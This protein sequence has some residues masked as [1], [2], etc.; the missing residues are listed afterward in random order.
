MKWIFIWVVNHVYNQLSGSP[1]LH[2]AKADGGIGTEGLL[3][4][5]PAQPPAFPVWR[6][7]KVTIVTITGMESFPPFVL[8]RDY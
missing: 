1:K 8:A 5:T 6:K 3:K 7:D 4:Y 2:R